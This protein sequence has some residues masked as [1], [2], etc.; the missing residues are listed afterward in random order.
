MLSRAGILNNCT[1]RKQYDETGK[2][3]VL[4]AGFDMGVGVKNA[5]VDGPSHALTSRG[6]ESTLQPGN[7]RNYLA[8]HYFR[9]GAKD[10]QGEEE[11]CEVTPHSEAAVPT[12]GGKPIVSSGQCNKAVSLPL[13]GT[14]SLPKF[15]GLVAVSKQEQKSTGG[16]IKQNINAVKNLAATQAFPGDNLDEGSSL[17][18]LAKKAKQLAQPAAGVL[19]RGRG[20]AGAMAGGGA[21]G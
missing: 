14:A 2:K 12:F 9:D 1:K 20:G 15:H 21:F 3:N 10:G 4:E 16:I 18:P 19:A 11:V 13:A 7:V 6:L 5:S 17:E 8:R